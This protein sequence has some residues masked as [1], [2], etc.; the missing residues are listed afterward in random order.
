MD[1]NL[2]DIHVCCDGCRQFLLE[3]FLVS[4]IVLVTN[5]YRPD[6]AM[7]TYLWTFIT[8]SLSLS[9]THTHTHTHFIV[10]QTDKPVNSV[11]PRYNT[12]RKLTLSTSP[13]AFI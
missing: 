13:A 5:F 11:C 7:F 9:H 12:N 8:L 1:I 3:T 10:L 6:N 4:S 2:F